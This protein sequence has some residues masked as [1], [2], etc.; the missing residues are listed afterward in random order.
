[1]NPLRW[2]K[3]WLAFL[4]RRELGT[5]LA[6]FRI[7]IGSCM[8]VMLCHTWMAGAINPLWMDSADGGVRNISRTPWLVDWLGGPNPSVVF[9]LFVALLTSSILLTLGLFG[10][11][12]ALL[13]L[14]LHMN[15]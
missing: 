6:F 14:L 1:M 8:V 12:A 15:L 7:A 2:W 4:D 11:L 3:T 10:R 13:T 5:S 9:G